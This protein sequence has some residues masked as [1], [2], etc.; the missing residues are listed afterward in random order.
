MTRAHDIKRLIEAG[1]PDATVEVRGED[2]QHFEAIV[3]CAGFAGKSL[4][5][6]HQMVYRALG[7]NMRDAVIH[8]LALRTLTPEQAGGH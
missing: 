2:G 5:Q 6:Q 3:V 7:E 4:V 8:A 1:L